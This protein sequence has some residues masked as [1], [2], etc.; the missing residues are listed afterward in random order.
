MKNPAE[1]HFFFLLKQ[2]DVG[3]KFYTVEFGAKQR[4][5]LNRSGVT[6]QQVWDASITH[7]Q[8]T[9]LQ[10]TFYFFPTI[11]NL[12]KTSTNPS[13]AEDRSCHCFEFNIGTILPFE[14]HGHIPATLK[15]AFPLTLLTLL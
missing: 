4:E 9:T 3:T 12:A 6:E 5:Q 11:F 10:K 2:R 14:N 7:K 13:F 15:M 1:R 8:R